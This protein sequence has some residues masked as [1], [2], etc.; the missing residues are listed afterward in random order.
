MHWKKNQVL[1][2]TNEGESLE[3]L[4]TR[5][6]VQFFLRAKWVMYIHFSFWSTKKNIFLATKKIR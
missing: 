6:A 4:H 5:P 2:S 1:E 3:E